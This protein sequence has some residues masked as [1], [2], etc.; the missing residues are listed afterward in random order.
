MAKVLI[1]MSGGVDS[2]VAANII[3]AQG[4]DASGAIMTLH[5]ENISGNT[6][7]VED[8]RKVAESLSMPFY[9]FDYGC[10][11]DK[12]VISDFVDAYKNGLTPN[13]C[14]VCNKHIKFGVFLDKAIEMGFD[15]VATGHYARVEKNPSTGRYEV[16]KAKDE[17][18]DQSYMLYSL[19]QQQLSHILLPLGDYSKEDA[20]DIA[21]DSGFDNAEK[22]D[23]QDICFVPDGDY[24]CFIE[25]WSGTEFP[26]GDFVNKAGDF[27]AKHKGIINYTIGQ[28]KGLG[29]AAPAPYYVLEKDVANNRVVL[30]SNDDLFKLTLEAENVN[31]ISVEK[32]TDKISVKAKARYKQKE[33]QAYISPLENGNVLVEFETPQRAIT[34]GQSVVFYDGDVVLGGGI[35]K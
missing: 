31:L 10:E 1:A 35:I 23:S 32:L 3:K 34:P 21:R 16:K 11:F 2:S 15:Y 6:N 7:D 26:Q 14:V 5:G 17:T 18:K 33:T 12:Y 24:A 19:S 8:A 13:P 29:I 27:I 25:K 30:G 9:V 4:H 22:R 28:R 20:R